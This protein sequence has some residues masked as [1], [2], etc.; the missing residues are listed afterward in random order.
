MTTAPRIS[1]S[2]Q[3]PGSNGTVVRLP[4]LVTLAVTVVAAV[5]GLVV[6][7]GPGL[8]GAVIGGAMVALFFSLGAVVLGVVA[9]LA[10]T[11]SLLVA[12]LTYT[13]KVALLA[14][15]LVGLSRS[16]ALDSDVDAQWLGGTVVAATVGWLAAHLRTS[17]TARV[18]VFDLPPDAA[19]DR[20]EGSVPGPPEG[21]E[22][23]AR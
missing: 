1:G 10:P 4:L 17:L 13:L 15:V 6:D 9:R 21:Q 8:L 12:L 23:S 7:G 19:D 2:G 18:P 22:A 14:L 16:G 3:P 20:P 5:A 11:A